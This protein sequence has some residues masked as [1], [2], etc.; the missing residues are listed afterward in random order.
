MN[1]ILHESGIAKE[2]EFDKP[3]I[4]KIDSVNEKCIS[5]CH[6]KYFHTFDHLCVY[7]IKLTKIGN[8]EIINLT[9]S[10]K[11]MNLY[12]LNE[13]LTVARE[14]GVIYNETKKT[15]NKNLW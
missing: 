10:I 2:Q 7:D 5:H 14:R 12:D 6:N 9:I 3:L 8:N 15:N 11:S 13:K 1:G 4:Q